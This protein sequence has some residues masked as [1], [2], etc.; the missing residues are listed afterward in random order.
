MPQE[1]VKRAIMRGT[2]EIQGE[3]AP[4]EVTYE[5]YGPASV[6]MM[7]NTVTDNKNRTTSEIRKIISKYNGTLGTTGCVSWIFSQKGY[8]SV[9]KASISEDEITTLV[10]EIGVEDL[11]TDEE[12]IYEVITSVGDF[13]RVREELKKRDIIIKQ[14]EVTM[15]PKT[16]IK[17]TDKEAEQML[18]LMSE[19]DEQDDVRNV[20]AN[21]D[22]PKEVMEKVSAAV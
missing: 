6:A 14:A 22:I 11:K 4:E 17:L 15:L 18:N 20:Y 1:N 8:I 9:D 12:D 7:I 2:G 3:K 19:L 13:E 16:Y 10:I 5:G 21:F